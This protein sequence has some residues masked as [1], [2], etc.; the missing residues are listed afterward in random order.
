[1]LCPVAN[2]PLRWTI[3][4]GKLFSPDIWPDRSGMTMTQQLECPPRGNKSCGHFEVA[5][6]WHAAPMQVVIAASARTAVGFAEGQR[7]HLF[8]GAKIPG[9]MLRVGKAQRVGNARHGQI[10]LDRKPRN[11]VRALAAD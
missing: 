6:Q 4:I 3:S 10:G 8:G 11:L 9:K 1:M 5:G 2:Q 7:T